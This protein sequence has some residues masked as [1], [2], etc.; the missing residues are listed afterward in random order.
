MNIATQM[1]PLSP[2]LATILSKYIHVCKYAE[3]VKILQN[4]NP[5]SEP[6]YMHKWTA[7][8]VPVVA[9]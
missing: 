4:A 2:T 3:F 7:Y 5:T 6:P 8:S 9:Y 1:K